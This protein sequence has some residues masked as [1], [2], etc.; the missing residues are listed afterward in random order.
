MAADVQADSVNGQDQ[1]AVVAETVDETVETV[2]VQ[3]VR[4]DD[5]IHVILVEVLVVETQMVAALV[6]VNKRLTGLD[7]LLQKCFDLTKYD[8]ENY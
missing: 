4:S 6:L 2:D 8:K 7:C 5:N 1:T 3:T